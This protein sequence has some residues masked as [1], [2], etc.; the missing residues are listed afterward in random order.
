MLGVS[1]LRP[2]CRPTDGRTTL[3]LKQKE[4]LGG[5]FG[6]SGRGSGTGRGLA[7]NLLELG[8]TVQYAVTQPRA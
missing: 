1:G 6:G 5:V 8:G 3:T 7:V 2:T 4:G